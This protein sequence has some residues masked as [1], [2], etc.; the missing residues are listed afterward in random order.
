M[1][2]GAGLVAA[3]AAAGAAGALL[4]LAAGQI[5]DEESMRFPWTTFAINIA[6]SGLLG[7][8]VGTVRARRAADWVMPVLG[9]GLLG[10]FTTL[11]AVMLAAAPSLLGDPSLGAGQISPPGAPEMLAYLLISILFGT[12]AA[13]FGITLGGAVFGCAAMDCEDQPEAAASDPAWPEALDTG[14]LPEVKG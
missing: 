7:M 6:G 10:S 11:S 5:L 4:R 2:R 3:V 9:T 13:G 1:M 8:L 12:A 14:S